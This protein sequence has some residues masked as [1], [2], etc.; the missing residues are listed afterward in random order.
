MVFY[1]DGAASIRKQTHRK[2]TKGRTVP[3][4]EFNDYDDIAAHIYDRHIDGFHLLDPMSDQDEQ[5]GKHAVRNRVFGTGFGHIE[6][7]RMVQDSTLGCRKCKSKTRLRFEKGEWFI[8]WNR[9]IPAIV[10]THT[11]IRQG[12]S[13]EKSENPNRQDKKTIPKNNQI[14]MLSEKRI[15]FSV[16]AHVHNYNSP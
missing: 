1:C 12:L 11:D 7:L 5:P 8:S 4:E 6:R 13:I 15:S 3:T 14:N 2:T 9:P 10:F 16:T